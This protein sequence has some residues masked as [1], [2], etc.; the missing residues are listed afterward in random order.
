MATDIS[1]HQP[2]PA[3]GCPSAG[4]SAPGAA[5]R[6]HHKPRKFSSFMKRLANLKSSSTGP[7]SSLGSRSANVVGSQRS[8]SFS[9]GSPSTHH[10]KAHH[11]PSLSRASSNGHLSLAVSGNCPSTSSETLTSSNISGDVVDDDRTA[12]AS[13]KS[14]PPPSATTATTSAFSSPT[15]SVRSLTTTLTTIQSTAP[16]S[17]LNAN[18]N[19]HPSHHHNPNGPP[20]M[21]SAPFPGSGPPASPAPQGNNSGLLHPATYN[22]ATANGVWTDNASIIT[23]ASSSK[24]RRRHSADTDASV[25]AVAPSSVFGGSRESL[26]LSVLSGN[27]DSSIASRSVA[28]ERASLYGATSFGGRSVG[29]GD[30]ASITG[31]NTGSLMGE[32]S[33]ANVPVNSSPLVS[34]I[35]NR[36]S[37]PTGRH[38]R[39]SSAWGVE[40]DVDECD[41]RKSLDARSASLKGEGDDDEAASVRDGSSNVGIWH[42]VLGKPEKGRRSGEL[43]KDKLTVTT[44]MGSGRC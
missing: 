24:R 17:M 35:S 38:S 20:Q 44:T 22:A 8:A 36:D 41:E 5:E 40:G 9:H 39:R 43:S 21:Y 23:L 31:G 29:S 7:S 15:P 33:I 37:L 26:P 16:G 25:R 1:S 42:D 12:Q 27:L 11:L 13:T 14:R 34:P 32:I 6:A 3:V 19:P 28:G 10:A 2:P 30:A 18:Y 4:T